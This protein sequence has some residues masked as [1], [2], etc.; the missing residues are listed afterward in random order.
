MGEDKKQ[1]QLNAQKTGNGTI[2]TKQNF[3]SL[4]GSSL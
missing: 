2:T 3:S 1:I 4:S